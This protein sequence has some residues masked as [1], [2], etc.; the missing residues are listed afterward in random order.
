M[1]LIARPGRLRRRDL[2]LLAKIGLAAIL[3][4]WISDLLGADRPAFAAIVPLVA[5]RADDPYGALGLSLF[6][7]AGTVLGILLGIAALAIDPSAPLWL[8]AA[9]IVV[10]LLLGLFVRSS[11]EPINPIAAVTAV[12]V[13][14]VGKGRADAYGWIRI[15]E[16]FLGAV[17]TMAVAAFVWPPDPIA[18]LR[19]MLGDLRD[20]VSADLRDVAR[21]PG[22]PLHEADML[23]DERLRRS[24]ETGDTMP[25]ID[26][27]NSGL[28]WNPRHRG[29]RPELIALAVPIRELAAM[30]RYSRS[31]L[32]SLMGDPV[33]DRIR[34]W[35]QE[36]LTAFQEALRHADAAAGDVAEA[37]DPRAEIAAADEAL[38]RFASHTGGGEGAQLA[39]DLHGGTRAMIRVLKPETTARL[40]ALSLERY[41]PEGAR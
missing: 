8:V 5:L 36:G 29:R 17:V 34:T 19:E 16:T 15:W 2:Q 14:Y 12:V 24:M 33:G 10:S 22:L 26:R 3:A 21:F 25:T 31:L 20:D 4:W 38:E 6:R 23:L 18:G 13:I 41:G 32:W 1:A 9:T 40:R 11:N 39:V 30:S 37:R 35:P 27:A 28:R 7:V